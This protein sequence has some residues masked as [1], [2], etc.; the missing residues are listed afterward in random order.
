M[1]ALVQAQISIRG[2]TTVQRAVRLVDEFWEAV[3]VISER[4]GGRLSA[5]LPRKCSDPWV[6]NATMET[7]TI[8]YESASVQ[9]HGGQGRQSSIHHVLCDVVPL[10]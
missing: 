5:L 9:P 8:V 3:P 7:K 4:E 10:S 2:L 6:H 1:G